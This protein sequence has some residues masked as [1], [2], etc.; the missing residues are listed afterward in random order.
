[1][2]FLITYTIPS[3]TRTIKYKKTQRNPIKGI[4]A[5]PTFVGVPD[6]VEIA[7]MSRQGM[8]YQLFRKC[9]PITRFCAKTQAFLR[10]MAFTCGRE[11]C[12]LRPMSRYFVNITENNDNWSLQFFLLFVAEML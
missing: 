8:E 5:H 2:I 12:N 6:V 7:D 4:H 10:K 9:S 11:M 1:M 3:N